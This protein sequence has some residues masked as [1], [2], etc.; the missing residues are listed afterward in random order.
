ME[1]LNDLDG[2]LRGALEAIRVNA[3]RIRDIV[4]KLED[5][6]TDRVTV[7]GNSIEMIDIHNRDVDVEQGEGA[8]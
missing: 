3:L 2:E 4:D 6:R 1:E 5:I 7:C 8:R